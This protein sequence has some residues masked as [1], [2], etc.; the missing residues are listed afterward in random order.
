MTWQNSTK[1]PAGSNT[2]HYFS[3]FLLIGVPKRS[4][5]ILSPIH[6]LWTKP[7]PKGWNWLVKEWSWLCQTVW[8]LGYDFD[9]ASRNGARY[10]RGG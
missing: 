10:G 7:D 4:V 8:Q 9:I 5:L 3:Q 2:V 1:V 6:S